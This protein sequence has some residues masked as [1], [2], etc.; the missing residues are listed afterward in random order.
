[1]TFQG[2]SIF[3]ILKQTK[4]RWDNH[5]Y[6][7]PCLQSRVIIC[8]YVKKSIVIM[9]LS[10]F[11]F[12]R[13]YEPA[14]RWNERQFC[15][16]LISNTVFFNK[17][18]L[19]APSWKA[20]LWLAE[21]DLGITQPFIPSD[22]TQWKAFTTLRRHSLKLSLVVLNSAW[23]RWQPTKLSPRHPSPRCLTPR[24]KSCQDRVLSG[25]CCVLRWGWTL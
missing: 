13:P 21:T 4:Y 14:N 22:R 19:W 18:A 2:H 8:G 12:L 9:S 16:M 3:L 6:N 10:S 23:P 11:L 17:S 20:C 24:G 1:M 25:S 15:H 7:C 5:S